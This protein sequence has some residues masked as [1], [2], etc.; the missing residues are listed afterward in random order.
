MK[1]E[2]RKIRP[3]L[4]VTSLIPVVVLLVIAGA[5]WLTVKLGE[6][7]KM[8]WW[9]TLLALAL[10]A[11]AVAYL[12]TLLV[13]L[14]RQI[15]AAGRHLHPPEEQGTDR[16]PQFVDRLTGLPARYWFDQTL[17]SELA[18]SKRYHRPLSL[19]VLDVDHFS[20]LSRVH[21][22][23][24]GDRILVGVAEILRSI[25]RRTDHLARFE[26]DEFAVILSETGTAGAVTVGE[27][28]RQ[29]VELLQF[30]D[31]LRTTASI[32]VTTVEDSD[33]V[34]SFLQRGQAAAMTA[35]RGGGNS[36]ETATY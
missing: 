36:V 3:R 34:E 17:S 19:V 32:G 30:E 11:L 5:G 13:R 8:Y 21:G 4:L 27:K 33:T 29:A 14:E 23:A 25:L 6:S 31:D 26:D 7:G 35:R 18:R 16:S 9:V 12:L 24:Y 22:E 2:R 28:L 1:T 15:P 10:A 20:R